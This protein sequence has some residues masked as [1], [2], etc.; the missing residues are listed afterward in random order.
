MSVNTVSMGKCV[1][2]SKLTQNRYLKHPVHERAYAYYLSGCIIT[3]LFSP[4]M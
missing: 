1:L 3:S 2:E 4:R